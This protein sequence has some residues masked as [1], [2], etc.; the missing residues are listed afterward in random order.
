MRALLAP[1]ATIAAATPT[2]RD[3][4]LDLLRGLSIAVVVIGHWLL[5][6][7]WLDDGHLRAETL[8]TAAPAVGWITWIVQVMPLFFLVGGVVNVRSWRAARADRVSY[9]TWVARRAARL[10]RPTTVLVWAWVVLASG[11]LAIGVDR[12]LILL[13]A[14]NALVPLW[15]LAVYLLMIAALPVL[16]A[17]Y[18]RWGAAV[19]PALVVGAGLVDAATLAG[20]PLIEFVNYPLVWAVPTVLGFAWA[21]G[22]LEGRRVRIGLP[23]AALA[24]L[25]AAVTVLG[26]PI[27]LVGVA[28]AGGPRV[29]A[30]LA[31]LGLAQAG[32]AL[33]ARRP[34]TAWL[35][36]PGP[37]AAVVRL[38]TV[39]MTVYLWHLTVMVL[40]TGLL[41]AVA[42]WWVVEPLTGAWWM[43]RPLW[44][45][46]LTAAL[47][48]VVGL[49]LPIERSV[50]PVAPR[51]R[52]RR[53]VAATVVTVLVASL[54]TAAVTVGG[55]LGPSG[56]A[57]AVLLTAAARLAGAF[58]T[59]PSM[60]S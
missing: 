10:L 42:T 3:R 4:Y 37:W 50:P 44:L 2:D 1:A 19:V 54:A 15:F 60:A 17:A 32:V 59:T 9:A 39:A 41:A 11:A 52:G 13:G 58:G 56:L 30:T 47:M 40:V 57:A 20:V 25:V 18:T 23:L 55:T 45:A 33:A 29:P 53:A 46:G 7:L 24:G 28:D 16:L 48:P 14:R 12:S 51:P 36:R 49:L 31:L 6:V 5:P 35:Q 43:T 8:L 26:Y 21:D 34:A 22:R 38:N 27:T